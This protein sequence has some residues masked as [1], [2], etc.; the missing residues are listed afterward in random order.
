M[1]ENMKNRCGK[2]KMRNIAY[3]IILLIAAAFV[4][5]AGT[6]PY[7]TPTPPSSM[8]C[9]QDSECFYDF[10]ATDDEGDTINFSIDT[11]PFSDS[12]DPDTGVMNFT[13]TNAEVGYYEHT[14][15]I[16]KEIDTGNGSFALIDWYIINVNDLPNITSYYP[17]NIT[18]LT[19]KENAW[20]I[21][22]VTATDPDL[23]H[24]DALNHTWLVDG[25]LNRT[26][27]NFTGNQA[28]YTP[29]FFSAGIH[30][31]IVNV[32][33]NQSAFDYINWT[34]NVTNENR[35]PIFQGLIA[36]ITLTEDTPRL[37]EINLD[38][39]FYDNDTDDYPLS[40][41]T[42]FLG[43]ENVTIVINAT[44]PNNVSLFPDH[45]FFGT[46]KVRFRCYDGYNYTLSN[47]V[48]INVTGVNDPPTIQQVQNQTAY[49]DTLYQL[50]I[51]ANDP[52]E[53]PLTYYDNTTLFNINPNTG[54]ITET[55][56]TSDIGNY[57]ILINV[58]D[59]TTNVSTAFNLTI[60]NNT[61][62]VIGGK[63]LPDIYTTEDNYTYI[64]FNATD[65]DL[66]D[67]INF[68]AVSVPANS[69]FTVVTTNSSAEGAEAYM[70]F[71]PSQSDVGDWTIT[72]TAEDSKGAQDTD[73]FII[74]ISNI[75]HD[76][77]LS[78]IPN[79]R[80]KVNKTFSTTV[81]ASDED[82]NLHSFGDNTTLFNITTGGT[83]GNATGL[84]NFT[85]DDP[86]V[87]EHWVNI[88]I[89][90]TTGRYDWQLVLFNV[91][92]NTPPTLTPIGNLTILEDHLFEYQV[93]ASDPDP[94][95]SILYYDNSTLFNVSETTGLISFT[96][97]VSQIGNYIINITVTDG[98][99][100]ASTIM[101]LTVGE[102]NDF[103]YWDPLLYEYYTN[104]SFAYNT[105]IWTP[106][107]LLNHTTNMTVWNSTIY[108]DNNT[109]VL[110]DAYDE[111]SATL[112]FSMEYVNF[113]NAS[114]DAVTTGIYLIN[115]TSYDGDT[116]SANMTPNNSQ[117]GVYH[118]NFTVDDTTGRTN[119][120]TVRLVVYNVNDAPAILEYW[121]NMTHN[122][123]MPENASK[124]FN[125]T[126]TDIDYGD[127]LHYQWVL[128]GEN[129]SGA[130]ISRYN[131]STHF[132]SAGIRNLTVLVLDEQNISTTLNWTV[133]VTNVNR[134]GWFGQIREYNYTHFNAG[135]TK[136]NVSALPGDLGIVLNPGAF[137]KTG[138]FESKVLDT[139]ETNFY[140]EF[141]RINWTG[142]TTPANNNTNI[143]F[144]IYFKTRTA[145]GLTPLSCPST[146]SSNYSN[147]TYLTS[148]SA[149]AS[150]D[151]RCIQYKFYLETNDTSEKP[152]ISSVTL[153]YAIA[154]REQEQNTN[155]SWIDL[156]TYFY[157]PDIDDNVT[158]NVTDTN[159]TKIDQVNITINPSTHK[160]NVFTGGGFLGKIELVFNMFD[161]YNSTS[162]NRIN[163]TVVE[164]ETFPEVIIVPVGGGGAVSQPVPYEVP[165]YVPTPVSF[166]LIT[167]QMVTTYVNDTMEVPINIFNQNFTMEDL[168]LKASTANK[169]V[170]LRLSRE[171]FPSLQPNQKEFITLFVES[172]R[173][174]GTYEIIIEAEADAISVAEDGTEKK[175]RFREKAKIF[176]NSLLKSEGNDTQVNTKLAFAED[177]LSTNPECLELNEFLKKAR[178]ILEEGDT[179]EA[180]KMLGQVIESCKYLIAPR[181]VEPELEKPTQVYGMPTESAF[182][183][184]TV[185]IVTLIVAIALIIGWA[186]LKSRKQELTRSA[187]RTGI[188]GGK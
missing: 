63:P 95:D 16:V 47:N 79:Y 22:N 186:H 46:N 21:F 130:N 145:E 7:F 2:A 170:E 167:P 77:I 143:T 151:E 118:I 39:Y 160:V 87:G 126:A 99:A 91:T 58:S 146:I 24:G 19:V 36:N 51:V 133:N 70:A 88:T 147:A 40:Y 80:M 68:S 4:I 61:A 9:Y 71:T 180:D 74:N 55:F 156:D 18:N 65:V 125:V 102:F 104:E 112:S 161:G 109:N 32:T 92:Y 62:P 42:I 5:A 110:M 43:R 38:D 107:M 116:A 176:V 33:D 26:L 11:P 45:N 29:D 171:F 183:L 54:F 124:M 127:S 14:W 153:G 117:V 44:E 123:T 114:N 66:L 35:A 159:G 90:D 120:T 81:S 137:I 185:S 34:V 184:G 181:E 158:Y 163:L 172:H 28:N 3:A 72:L 86:E 49:A 6:A 136:T 52:D 64:S 17:P 31:I 53:D 82:N 162:S 100:N 168:R 169:D 106:E 85:P 187:Q 94:Q 177:L 10:N 108:E 154:D 30:T 8:T 48:T 60:I 121:P 15:A 27:L 78:A 175:S 83:G 37:D 115:L 173:T 20:M 164:A 188:R 178:G 103:P 148:G 141:A 134:I 128:D 67:T 152:G 84:I 122:V 89:N 131:Y 142:N 138:V 174:Y 13:P 149:I 113:T 182:I 132:F 129:I 1:M 75:E 12:I 165:K 101:N 23:I 135:V 98:E 105:T 140:H 50:Q 155:Q 59:G 57:S 93:N 41:D 73:T 76:P 69:L 97:N 166:R 179:S 56:P 25:V 96:P 157:D 144:D 139:G 150:E 119:T 111:E